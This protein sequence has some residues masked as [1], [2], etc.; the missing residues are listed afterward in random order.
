M[1]RRM[2]TIGPG[3]VSGAADN[4]PTTVA[5]LA[6]VGASTTYGLAWLVVLI[7]PMMAI[8]QAISAQVGLVCR[9]GLQQ[10]VSQRYGQKIGLV[11]LAAIFS[12][13][14]LTLAAD[15]EAGGA[16]VSVL[17]HLPYQWFVVPFAVLAGA[18]LVIG[19]FSL[20][21]R[22][23]QYVALVFFA[24]VASAFFAHPHWDDVLRHTLV[25]HF[26]RTAAYSAGALALLGTTLTSY[27]YVWETIA[28]AEHH[29]PLRRLGLVQA[30]AMIGMIFAGIVFFFIIVAT[31]A[32]LGVHHHA[33]ETAQDA[34]NALEPLAGRYASVIFGIGLLASALL[35]VP[36]LAGTCAYVSAEAFGWRGNLDDQFAGA[37]RFYSMLILSLVTAVV[38][39]FL[40]VPP[41][42]LLFFSSILGGFGTPITLVLLLLVAR[43]REV[44]G[45]HRIAPWLATGGWITALVVV[46]A[47]IVFLIQT[48][49]Q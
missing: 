27:A 41:V 19:R 46:A 48:I 2:K 5:T 44:M 29:P 32:T 9:E 49:R 34:A 42:R 12:V 3:I 6:V 30:D 18:L 4:D 45:D 22:V 47:C 10:A 25:P 43:D 17:T 37:P 31:G 16:A 21:E 26:D 11:C 8:V 28:V 40:S 36:I 39:T 24:Y 38:I 14:I 35:A 15:L 33:V 13:N 7:V 23:L 20:I 1:L